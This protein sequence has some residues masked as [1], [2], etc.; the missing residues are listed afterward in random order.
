MLKFVKGNEC[1]RLKLA[2]A[3]ASLALLIA[4]AITGPGSGVS[5]AVAGT[6]PLDGWY[7]LRTNSVPYQPQDVIS[8]AHGGLWISAFEGSEY[9]PGVW[10]HASGDPMG[11][12]R[13]ITNSRRNN[14]L[15]DSYLTL[16]E[17]SEL[18]ATVRCAL[19]DGQGNAWYGLANRQ[20]LCEK[21][22]GTLCTFTM[23]GRIRATFLPARVRPTWTACIASV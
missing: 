20:V 8:D 18:A 5:N 1:G 7:R 4:F 3:F 10:Y 9:D 2:K 17:K 13:Y 23:Q 12:F 22:D 14:A 16:V 6:E 19:K 11:T 21:P 15:S